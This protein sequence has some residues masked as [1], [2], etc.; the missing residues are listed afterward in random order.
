MNSPAHDEPNADQRGEWDSPGGPVLVATREVTVNGQPSIWIFSEF[1]TPISLISLRQWVDAPEKW[2]PGMLVLEPVPGTGRGDP[3]ANWSGEFIETLTVDGKPCY[4]CLAVKT[5]VAANYL[6]AVYELVPR[7]PKPDAVNVTVDR[8]F[9]LASEFGGLRRVKVLKIVRTDN[10]AVNQSLSAAQPVWTQLLE[11]IIKQD[12]K[13]SVKPSSSAPDPLHLIQSVRDEWVGYANRTADFVAQSLSGSMSS[14]AAGT[15]G[16]S[17]AMKDSASAFWQLAQNWAHM[18]QSAAKLAAEFDPPLGPPA[19]VDV[20]PPPQGTCEYSYCMLPQSA[21]PVGATLDGV[22]TQLSAS[23][24]PGEPC[25]IPASLVKLTPVTVQYGS[26]PVVYG[27]VRVDLPIGK[28]PVGLYTG[29]ISASGGSWPVEV[30]VS[31]ST[32]TG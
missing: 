5:T 11:A 6:A 8:G 13:A 14:V 29:Q 28:Y 32:E 18:W 2:A 26:P 16:T 31:G 3:A 4:T 25:T 15:Y 9:L 10:A 27:A 24:Q 17:E 22:L 19:S 12:V 7:A 20:A 1:L 23:P 30:Y 21:Q